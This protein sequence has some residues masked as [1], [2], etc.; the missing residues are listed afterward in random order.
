[1]MKSAGCLVLYLKRLSIDTIVLDE[2]L[3]PGEW[4]EIEVS[5]F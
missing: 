3:K 4:K 2:N 5:L 1:M